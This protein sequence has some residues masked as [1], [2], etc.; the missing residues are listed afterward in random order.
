MLMIDDNYKTSILKNKPY[1]VKLWKNL[2]PYINKNGFDRT[3][4]G[5]LLNLI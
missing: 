4:A 2:I 5:F 1:V 3:N